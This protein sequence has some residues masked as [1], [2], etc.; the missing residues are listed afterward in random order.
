MRKYSLVWLFGL[1]PSNL[2]LPRVWVYQ[3]PLGVDGL[4][5]LLKVTK[6]ISIFKIH[7]KR[8]KTMSK[9]MKT[10]KIAGQ[11]Q[12]RKSSQGL[13]YLAM[14]YDMFRMPSKCMCDDNQRSHV[15]NKSRTTREAPKVKAKV[16]S[17]FWYWH[18]KKTDIRFWDSGE[19]RKWSNQWHWQCIYYFT[20]QSPRTDNHNWMV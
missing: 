5:S 6:N 4:A 7:L 8:Q 17:W 15:Y 20:R 16:N 3:L 13:W 9:P 14:Q 10:G 19:K 12:K 2:S 11:K 18:C 1:E